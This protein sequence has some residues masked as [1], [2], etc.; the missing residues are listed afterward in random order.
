MDITQ[1]RIKNPLK[2]GVIT[3]TI[4]GIMVG[5]VRG[6]ESPEVAVLLKHIM[7]QKTK[8]VQ[9]ATQDSPVTSTTTATTTESTGQTVSPAN[10]ATN[11]VTSSPQPTH[12]AS[13]PS[14]VAVVTTPTHTPTPA[15][16]PTPTSPPVTYTYI[17]GS[18]YAVGSFAV[19]SHTEKIG[20]QITIYDDTI[21]AT[22]VTSMADN[23]TSQHY[24]TDFINNYQQYVV[25]QKV[26]TLKLSKVSSA[27]LTPVGFNNALAQIRTQAHY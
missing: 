14:T 10:S 1:K 6:L 17:N 12:A 26:A 25:G 4:L 3:L 8:P 21:T 11:S 23:G 5:S 27:S 15:P 7:T 18:Y 2:A 19:P 13:S 22:S 9:V 24:E 20:I 16:T